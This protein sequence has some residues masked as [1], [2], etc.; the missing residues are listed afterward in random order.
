MGY[1]SRFPSPAEKLFSFCR[2]V[3]SLLLFLALFAFVNEHLTKPIAKAVRPSHR[4]MLIKT[5]QLPLLDSV[6]NMTKEDRG[7]FFDALVRDHQEHFLGIDKQVLQHWIE[8]AG[9]SFPSGHSFNAFM[10]ATI[11]AFSLS[12]ARR[13][14][15]RKYCVL[16]FV[17]AC[18]VGISRVMLGAHT[19]LDVT[20]GAAL[21]VLIAVIFLYFDTTRNW[22]IH[23]KSIDQ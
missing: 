10:L 19:P 11:L 9:Y 15:F 4:Y 22:I 5:D 8:E 20:V 16:P 18:L 3:C 17:W 7:I 2:S 13:K 12:T 14:Q 6:Y 1:A 23:R 21:G